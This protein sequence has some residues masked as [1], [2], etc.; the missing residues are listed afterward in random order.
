MEGERTTSSRRQKLAKIVE[1]LPE[2]LRKPYERITLDGMTDEEFITFTSE[3]TTEVE[4][5]TNDI[6]AKGAVFGRPAN[7]QQGGSQTELTKDQQAAIAHREG[8]AAGDN[9]Q[10]F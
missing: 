9:E 3:V 1:Q 2:T 5:I 8:M 6:K 4:G 10:P 7:S